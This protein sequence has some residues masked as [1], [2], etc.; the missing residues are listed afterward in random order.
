[1]F[2]AIGFQYDYFHIFFSRHRVVFLFYLLIDP[3]HYG[4]Q[5]FLILFIVLNK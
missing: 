3:G 1:M 4:Q 2:V 5:I